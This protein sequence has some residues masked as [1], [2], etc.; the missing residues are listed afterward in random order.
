MS[1]RLGKVIGGSL[2][3]TNPSMATQLSELASYGN[4]KSAMKHLAA[5]L[6]S[7]QSQAQKRAAPKYS[8]QGTGPGTRSDK[9]ATIIC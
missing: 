6:P 1:E 9:G 8:G 3:F 4:A 5:R 7:K 2:P